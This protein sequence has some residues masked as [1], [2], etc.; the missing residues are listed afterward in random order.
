MT[1]FQYNKIPPHVQVYGK[2]SLQ[3]SINARRE[4]V[5]KYIKY[6]FLGREFIENIF[7]LARLPKT[8]VDDEEENLS[9]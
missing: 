4:L 3:K 6:F 1:L 8:R 7:D 9:I 2:L 5:T